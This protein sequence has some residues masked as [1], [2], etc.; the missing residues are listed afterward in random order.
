MF[1]VCKSHLVDTVLKAALGFTVV[2]ETRGPFEAIREARVFS[3]PSR[4]TLEF[5][6][7]EQERIVTTYEDQDDLDLNGKAKIKNRIKV[8]DQNITFLVEIRNDTATKVNTDFKDFFRNLNKFIYDGQTVA[9]YIDEQSPAVQNDLKGNA[10]R[11][12]PGAYDFNDNKFYEEHP[13]AVFMEIEFQG[14]I[15]EVPDPV[16]PRSLMLGTQ[17][18]VSDLSVT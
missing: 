8:A 18:R 17:T 12:V 6:Y 7:D 1:D 4:G 5:V 14:A 11:V 13:H 16:D 15:Y 10:I 2:H 3:M 9:N